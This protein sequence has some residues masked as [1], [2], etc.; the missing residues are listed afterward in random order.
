MLDRAT[1]EWSTSPQMQT[2]AVPRGAE[3]VAQREQVE[4]PLGG[5]LVRAVAGVDDVGLD[6][7][8]EEARRPRGPGGARPPCRSSSPRGCARCR[9]GSRPLTRSLE[10]EATFTVSADRRFSANSNEMRVRVEASKKR[11]TIVAPRSVGTF[12]IARSEISLNGSATS[13]MVVICSRVIP[14]PSRSL[15]SPFTTRRLHCC[16]P[17]RRPR[18]GH[19]ASAPT[20]RRGPPDAPPPSCRRH[21]AGWATRAR[22]DRRARRA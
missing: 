2:L 18:R 13:R 11:L 3:A 16:H 21:R 14:R 20:R 9:R 22:R 10:A 1:R 17:A 4:Q 6:A 5:V 15:P 19:R 12:L 7:L 8:R